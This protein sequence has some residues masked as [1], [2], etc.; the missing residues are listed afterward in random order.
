MKLRPHVVAILLF[1]A[2][3]FAQTAAP[4]PK[5]PAPSPA[6][7]AGGSYPVMSAAA[8]NRARQFFG[9]FESGQSSALYAAFSP[10]M[11][12]RSSDAQRPRLVAKTDRDR[13]GT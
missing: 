1:P 11:K 3:M 7:A 5:K 8:E 6:A 13:V 10:Q 9:F 2:L 4:A 12:A